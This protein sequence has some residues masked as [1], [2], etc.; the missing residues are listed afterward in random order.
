[1]LGATSLDGPDDG[2]DEVLSASRVVR[3]NPQ[4]DDHDGL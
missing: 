3:R 1:M 2:E 4:A